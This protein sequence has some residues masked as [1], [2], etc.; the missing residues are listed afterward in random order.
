MVTYLSIALVAVIITLIATRKARAG[1]ALLVL[2][3]AAPLAGCVSVSRLATMDDVNEVRESIALSA[4]AQ[5]DAYEAALASGKP[6][7]EAASVAFSVGVEKQREAQ[8][9]AKEEGGG[10][11]WPLWAELAA[12]ILGGGTAGTVLTRVVRG[13]PLRS[14]SGAAKAAKAAATV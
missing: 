6:V 5:R 11:A 8:A 14:G 9:S 7:G 13:A 2:V 4:E 1:A 3:I 12:I 10:S